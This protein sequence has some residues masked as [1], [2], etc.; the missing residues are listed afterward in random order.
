MMVRPGGGSSVGGR[1]PEGAWPDTVTE[2]DMSGRGT[3][4]GV[5]LH[6]GPDDGPWRLGSSDAG[7]RLLNITIVL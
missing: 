2:L 3:A 5:L 6:L 4:A 7:P 1:L